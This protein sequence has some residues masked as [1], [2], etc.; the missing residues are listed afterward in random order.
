M[1]DWEIL[2]D[3]Y[4]E[5]QKMLY[6]LNCQLLQEA[7]EQEIATAECHVYDADG[8]ELS[9]SATMSNGKYYSGKSLG[10]IPVTDEIFNG[11]N[12]LMPTQSC[13]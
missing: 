11:V 2:A 6:E 4:D 9:S 8:Y 10:E 3:A 7:F 12:L 13:A 1:I 5:R